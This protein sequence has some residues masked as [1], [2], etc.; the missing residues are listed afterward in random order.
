MTLLHAVGWGGLDALLE[1][2][3][4]RNGT[5]T[6][7]TSSEDTTA[8]EAALTADGK[9]P[10]PER[11]QWF[12]LTLQGSFGRKTLKSLKPQRPVAFF[13]ITHIQTKGDVWQLL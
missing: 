11:R 3:S 8:E 9:P 2:L 10:V 4:S 6:T 5:S 13:R 1:A 12:A 7:S